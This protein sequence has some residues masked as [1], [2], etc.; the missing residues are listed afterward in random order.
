M[1]PQ[2]GAIPVFLFH[3]PS[4]ARSRLARR[5][6]AGII[7]RAVAPRAPTIRRSDRARMLYPF[8]I[9]GL[10]ALAITY[11]ATAFCRRLARAIGA[12]DYPADRKI[13]LHPTPYLGGLALLIGMAGAIAVSPLLVPDLLLDLDALSAFLVGATAACLLGLLDDLRPVPALAKLAATF[14]IA[15]F[16]WSEG[17]R[18]GALS[19]PGGGAVDLG[20]DWIS[21]FVTIAWFSVVM[22]AINV[23]DGLDGLAS[24]ICAIAGATLFLAMLAWGGSLAPALAIIIVGAALGF[25]PHNLPTPSAKVFLGD[26]GSLLLG[27]SLAALSVAGQAKTTSVVALAVPLMALG[28]PVIDIAFAFARRARRGANPFKADRRHIHHRLMDIGLPPSR[29]LMAFIPFSV[30]IRTLVRQRIPSPPERGDRL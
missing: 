14:G 18:I 10:V 4:P 5:L 12:L 11:A 23:I 25:L 16:M 30:L 19:T 15:W 9:L 6:R 3:A 8:L 1:V 20:S 13:H 7:S 29:V 27:F 26:A 28:V 17:W 22:H 24:G 21:L 2:T